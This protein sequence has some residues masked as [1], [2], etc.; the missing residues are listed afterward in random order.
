[1]MPERMQCVRCGEVM[2]AMYRPSNFRSSEW[3]WAW[4]CQSCGMTA[5]I[6][7]EKSDP[8]LRRSDAI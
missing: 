4:Y 7:D 8:L 2:M 5:P 3:I 6:S 1:M